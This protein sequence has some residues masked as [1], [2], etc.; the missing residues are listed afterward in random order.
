MDYRNYGRPSI[1]FGPPLTDWVKILIIVNVAV[2]IV[3]MIGVRG[4]DTLFGL[5]PSE[6]FGRLKLW[7]FVTYMFLHGGFWHIFFNMFMLWMFGSELERD[8]GPDTFIR[9][10]FFT[11][12]G[13]GLVSWITAPG[14]D[15]GIIGASG[16]IFGILL[17]YALAY[18]N[19]QVLIYFLFPVKV[20]YL[21]IGLCALNFFAAP[22]SAQTGIAHFAHLG[23]LLFGY[24]YLRWF[25]R[26]AWAAGSGAAGWGPT[27]WGA[28]WR[29]W[30]TK[31]RMKVVDLNARRDAER[32]FEVD[33]ILEKITRVGVE[34]LTPEE[35]KLLQDESDRTGM[36][37]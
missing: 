26:S 6:V 9:F 29:K 11:G 15:V 20:K 5:I 12:I 16:A 19:R 18:P 35:R 36:D 1:R 4:F 23:G 17:A 30:Q 2:F 31:R 14:S 22:K 10:Y 13:A 8:W 34:G 32:R 21:V 24:I 25:M 33:K 37:A 3:Q 28:S 27:S 7:Q